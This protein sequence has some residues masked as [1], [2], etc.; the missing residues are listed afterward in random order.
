MNKADWINDVND[1]KEE[2][3]SIR[4]DFHQYPE[5]GFEVKRTANKVSA[6]LKSW[7]LEVQEEIGKTGIVSLLKGNKPGKTIALRADM[8]ALPIK[9][10]NTFNY[11]SKYQG[12]M[13]A[14]GHDGHTAMLL[15]AAKVL[16]KYR[17]HLNG[18]IK[19]IFQPAEEGPTPGGAKPMIEDGALDDVEEIYGLHLTTAYDT[20]IIGMNQGSAMAS[21][22]VFEVELIG[23]G[24]HAGMP[25][26]S[27]DAILMATKLLNEIQYL[28][29]RENDPLEPLVISVGTING[30]FASNVIAGNVVISGTIRTHSEKVRED[31]IYKIERI[32]KYVSESC[33]GDYRLNIE[34]GLPPLI[35]HNEKLAQAKLAAEKVVGKENTIQLNKASMGGEDFAYYLQEIPG[36]YLWIGARNEAKNKTYLMHHPKFDFDEDA[37]L[38]GTKFYIR[39][40]FD[41]LS[42][43]SMSN[44]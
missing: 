34:R 43:Y 6:L 26:E 32:S 13:H 27:V 17:D 39:L 18:N 11:K 35:N 40:A 20:G 44:K 8:D 5:V 22:D 15:G 1:I 23:K 38:V 7:G 29:S 42:Q 25:H 14:C 24:G 28:V 2:I 21:T 37:L 31:T 30:G 12:K 3:I 19:F 4:R 41:L 33:G 36:A 10:E 16:S 9:E